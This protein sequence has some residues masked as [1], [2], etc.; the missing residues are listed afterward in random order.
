MLWRPSS[1]DILPYPIF[2][3]QHR[4]T[5]W[6]ASG[7]LPFWADVTY[8]TTAHWGVGG[9]FVTQIVPYSTEAA[10][11]RQLTLFYPALGPS[12]VF[13]THGVHLGVML[14]PS[15]NGLVTSK[16]RDFDSPKLAP[17]VRLDLA[18]YEDLFR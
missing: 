1:G 9:R 8:W 3:W 11:A 18:I 16:E 14:G 13:K 12:V 6:Q 15:L 4:G 7:L 5:R 2:G 10:A 17:F